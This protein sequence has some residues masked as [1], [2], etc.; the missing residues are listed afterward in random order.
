MYINLASLK[1]K[2][3]VRTLPYTLLFLF[4]HQDQD[5]V[6]HIDL[7]PLLREGLADLKR[8]A[9]NNPALSQKKLSTRDSKLVAT[10]LL[11]GHI[12]TANIL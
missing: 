3:K 6:G 7:K 2:L 12:L 9:K 4:P 10:Y 8:S 11:Q 1:F 5:T